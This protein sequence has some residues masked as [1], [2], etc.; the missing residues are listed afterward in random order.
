MLLLA[1]AVVQ[2]TAVEEEGSYG[3]NKLILSRE[4]PSLSVAIGTLTM[5]LTCPCNVVSATC[6]GSFM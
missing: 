1:L 3:R 2:K 6:W 5:A 4:G